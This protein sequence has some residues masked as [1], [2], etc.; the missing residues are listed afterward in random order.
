MVCML[1]IRTAFSAPYSAYMIEREAASCPCT[2]SATR[3]NA[4]ASL[5]FYDSRLSPSGTTRRRACAARQ[6]HCRHSLRTTP[7]FSRTGKPLDVSLFFLH[8]LSKRIT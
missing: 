2:V 4:Q 6:L 8:R 3:D 7:L 1:R 5:L